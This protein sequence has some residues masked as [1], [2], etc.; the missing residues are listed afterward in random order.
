MG[1]IIDSRNK[2]CKYKVSI[3]KTMNRLETFEVK[4]YQEVIEKLSEILSF[5]EGS[6]KI[7]EIRIIP[8]IFW[9]G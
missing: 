4:G 6:D 9:V 8:S 1:Y 5:N 3:V 7:R 2:I